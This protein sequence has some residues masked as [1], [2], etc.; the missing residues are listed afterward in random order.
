[1]GIFSFLNPSR[2]KDF[3]STRILEVLEKLKVLK[4]LGIFSNFNSSTLPEDISFYVNKSFN[5]MVICYSSEYYSDVFMIHRKSQKTSGW[6]QVAVIGQWKE[7]LSTNPDPPHYR[8]L[9][10][11]SFMY[12][13]LT[14]P[15]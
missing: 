6:V 11:F 8:W 13:I 14:R 7:F 4:G 5:I 10:T 15:L 3:D 1:M 9:T 2:Y 12:D